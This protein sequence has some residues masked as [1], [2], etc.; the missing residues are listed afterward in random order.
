M[1]SVSTATQSTN[2][3]HSVPGAVGTGPRV[4]LLV[5]VTIIVI[6]TAVRA[7]IWWR[8]D[9]G[10]SFASGVM[11]TMATDL[12]QGVFY[13]PLY[14]SRGYGG[15]RYFPLYFSLHALLLKLGMP[16]L[17]SAYL[18]SA[19]AIALLMLGTFR[20]LRELG[21][22][23]W[24]AAC[25]AVAMLAAG[26]VQLSLSTPQADG[27]AAALNVWGLA[28]IARAPHS[29]RRIF[30][31]SLFFTLAWSAKL[32]TVFG[33][34]AA[35]IWLMAT[36]YKR[37]AWL[38]AAETGCGYLLV[39]AAMMVGSRGRVV[40]IFKACAFG[41]ADWKFV[42][43]GPM[44]MES[45]AVYTDPGLVLFA[46]LALSALVFVVFSSKF[47]QNLPAL[48]L[49][50]TLA[51]TVMIFGSPGTAANHLLDVQVASVILLAA[52][53]A[54]V[55]SP[56]QKQLGVSGLALLTVIA[57][58]PLLR[59]TKTWNAWYHPH[60]FQRV[61]EIIGPANGPILSENPVIPALAGQYPYVLDP[62]M[63]QLLQKRRAGLA[64]P[65]LERLRNRSF[66]A[67]VL[68]A[69]PAN[70]S[71]RRW[72]DTVSFGPG[73]TSALLE[74]YKLATVVDRDWIYLPSAK[75]SAENGG[76]SS[77]STARG[78]L[79]HASRQLRAGGT[80]RRR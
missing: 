23:P 50:A 41:G 9:A 27:L 4:F 38:L 76:K 66:S 53:I 67:V 42:A 26:S 69:D 18:L 12:K 46:V 37:V 25:S 75:D 32:T 33:L 59:H 36:G 35:L 48:F 44:R 8:S 2:D 49:I 56:L 80:Y 61:I 60:Q 52:W 28:T 17:G 51:V 34:A 5:A 58:I 72:Y 10:I 43:S 63:V 11:I 7:W 74:N 71:V 30:L 21:A 39:A 65:L 6:I 3:T 29:S 62:W 70:E 47:L 78:L 40:E 14:D 19:A 24:L 20:L 31:A 45:M 79:A 55:P 16:L 1:S 73:F 77:D 54:N 15:T 13:R 57:A 64:E 68:S 22:E